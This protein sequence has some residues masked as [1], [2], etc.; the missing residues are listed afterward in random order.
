[1]AKL[2]GMLLI[3]VADGSC[4]QLELGLDESVGL[5]QGTDMECAVCHRQHEKTE[6]FCAY[7]HKFEVTGL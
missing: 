2:G 3:G 4:F 5:G 7:C 1:M 6:N